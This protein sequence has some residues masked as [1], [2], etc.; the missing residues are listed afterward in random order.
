MKKNFL[1]FFVKTIL[2]VTEKSKKNRR[3]SYVVVFQWMT[4][5]HK[6][7]NPNIFLKF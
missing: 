3:R 2:T 5:L 1:E 4:E 7:L 6:F